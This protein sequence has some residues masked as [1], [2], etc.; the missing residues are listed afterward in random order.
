VIPRLTLPRRLAQAV[1]AEAVAAVGRHRQAEALVGAPAATGLG[2]GEFGAAPAAMEL[3]RR[4]V[5]F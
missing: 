5:F 4:G 2:A 3:A 1:G